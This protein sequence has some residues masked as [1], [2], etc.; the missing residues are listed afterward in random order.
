[1]G[2]GIEGI[3]KSLSKLGFSNLSQPLADAI[4]KTKNARLQTK[5]NN[6]EIA[7]TS[8]EISTQNKNQLSEAQLRAGFG[9]KELKELQDK[10]D[11]LESQNA[12]LS[13]QTSKYKNIAKALTDQLTKANLIDFA[14]NFILILY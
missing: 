13:K 7:K 5:L 6:D 4:E 2:T 1:M 9:G 10:K 14:L 11:F 3:A 8:T 12:E